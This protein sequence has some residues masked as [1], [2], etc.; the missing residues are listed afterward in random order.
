MECQGHFCP[1]TSSV[2]LSKRKEQTR[3]VLGDRGQQC[4][5]ALLTFSAT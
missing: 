4:L 5:A 2:G 3:A 1:G